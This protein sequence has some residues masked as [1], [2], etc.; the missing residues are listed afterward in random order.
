MYP[1]IL[2]VPMREDLTSVGVQ[3]LRTAE[4]VDQVR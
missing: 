4:E 1:E 3:E 2:V